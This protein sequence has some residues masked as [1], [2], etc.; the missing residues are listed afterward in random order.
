MSGYENGKRRHG[1]CSVAVPRMRNGTI[2]ADPADVR[3]AAGL[4][5]GESWR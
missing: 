2:L 3:P 1:G 5:T 4:H